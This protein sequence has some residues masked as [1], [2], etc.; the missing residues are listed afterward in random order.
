MLGFYSVTSGMEIH[1]I[2][3]DPYSLSRGGGLTDTTLIEKYRMTDE[4]YDKKT[5]T[6]RD[7]IRKKREQDPNYKLKPKKT[8]IITTQQGGDNNQ[9]GTLPPGIESVEG[10]LIGDRCQI[11]PGKRRGVVKFI[12][13]VAGLKSG[14]WVGVHF[15]EPVG[16]NDG[17][18]KG[19][20]IFESLP[21]HGSFVRGMN[22]ATGNYPERDLLASD[23]EDDEGEAEVDHV[24]G[25]NS[26]CC[27]ENIKSEGSD[28][29]I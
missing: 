19:E 3:T 4:E 15:D 12:G 2:D 20:K 27:K 23:D 16:I 18:V 29:E 10:I 21:S 6:M 26:E 7:F 24:H 5:G 1:I 17:S 8:T 11:N 22:V 14:Y 25:E 28:D 9:E 13:E